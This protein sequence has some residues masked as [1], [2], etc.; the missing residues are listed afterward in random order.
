MDDEATEYRF[1]PGA[2]FVPGWTD[3]YN[4]GLSTERNQNE[5]EASSNM[6]VDTTMP[7]AP[8]D[9]PQ[10][11]GSGT[12]AALRALERA[13]EARSMT[14][15]SG[16]YEE[17][18]R[19]DWNEI[20]LLQGKQHKDEL[21]QVHYP[22]ATLNSGDTLVFIDFP[23]A[24]QGKTI[25]SDCD[26][27]AYVS[28]TLQVHSEKLI[29]TGSSKFAEMLN[30]TYQFR[31]QRRRKLVN[32]LPEGIKYVL[33]LTP[34]AEGDDLVF[35]M[36]ELS[37]PPGIIDWWQSFA[38]HG[39]SA[40]LVKGHDDICNCSKGPDIT[41]KRYVNYYSGSIVTADVRPDFVVSLP[42]SASQLLE[43]QKEQQAVPYHGPEHFDIPDYC[44][45]R[46]RNGIIRLLAAIE[47]K[48]VVLDSASRVWTV[49]GVAKILD[50]PMVMQNHVVTWIM[51]PGNVKFVE[52]L[53]EEALRIAFAIKSQSIAEA[54]FNILVNEL[55]LEEAALSPDPAWSRVTIFG[56]RKSD[57]GDELSNMIQHSARAMVETVTTVI[58]QLEDPHLLDKWDLPAWQQLLSIEQTLK[59]LPHLSELRSFLWNTSALIGALRSV[60]PNDY[61]E[62]LTIS[63]ED[64]VKE[65]STL[66]M[67]RATYT[68]PMEFRPFKVIFAEFS[69]VQKMLTPIPYM[70]LCRRWQGW[71][72]A[73]ATSHDPTTD[74]VRIASLVCDFCSEQVQHVVRLKRP[75]LQHTQHLT[76]PVILR[77]MYEQI[78]QQTRAIATLWMRWDIEI[79]PNIT[80]HM[81]LNLRMNE[82]K[83]LPLWAGGCDDGTG[84]V[85]EDFM[86]PA[87]MGPSGPG[88]A[89]HTGYTVPSDVSTSG[90]MIDGLGALSMRGSTTAASVDVHDSISTVY[91]P[92]NVIADDV[93]IAPSD[94]FS[95]DESIAEYDEAR[96]EVGPC[97]TTTEQALDNIMY[98]DA[99]D[100]DT[101]STI[102]EQEF[103]TDVDGEE[104]DGKSETGSTT[105]SRES[106][107]VV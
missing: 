5:D 87:E 80:R 17:T 36:T 48:M 97:N 51:H 8:I 96:A 2:T 42:P 41:Q 67:D 19:G 65:A 88:P 63:L 40:C 57:V 99:S 61:R 84:G 64:Q 56:R 6:D 91:R 15:P 49:L 7:S 34:P 98:E 58:R 13:Q 73:R 106:Y 29:A 100:N 62:A 71:A 47:D 27:L 85:F 101:A 103:L 60:I 83:Y 81:L 76:Q 107:V 59:D 52:V 77:N 75:D 86:P 54:A 4:S 68:L 37:L 44:P 92:D 104:D 33:D 11:S 16:F 72:F 70:A 21:Q 102:T 79:K 14:T 46:H 95:A 82:L 3:D 50:C 35:Q 94:A 43:L 105:S 10:S 78:H 18:A 53:P 22:A 39:V 90:S 55:A 1:P 31:V 28:Q 26:G 69:D 23:S 66:D 38:L 20:S 74:G 93:S 25:L 45:I 32:K 12:T 9:I 24:L 30:P 89:Y